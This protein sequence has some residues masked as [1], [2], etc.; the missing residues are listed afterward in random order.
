[1]TEPWLSGDLV[2]LAAPVTKWAKEIRRGE[3]VG[4]A[5]RRA[6]AVART[7]PSGPVFL[8]LPMD[9]LDQEVSGKT[10]PA[11]APPRLGPSPD[12]ERLAERLA[13]LDPDK[14]MVV[15]GDDL[16]ASV[17]GGLTAFVEAGAFPVWGTQLTSRVAFPS[18]HPCW[19]GVLKPDFAIMREHFEKAK[20][21]VLVGGRAFVA[22]PYRAAE[23]VPEGVAVLHVADN[24]EAFGREHAADMALIGDIGATLAVAAN[25]LAE[26]VDRRAVEARLAARGAHKRAAMEALRAEILAE[27]GAP[28]SPDAAVLAALDALPKDALIANDSAATFGRVQELMTTRPGPLLLLARRRARLQHAGR[29]RRV[30]RGRG[31]RRLVRRGRRGDVLAAGLVE[32]RAYPGEGDLL[33]VQQPP[34]RRPAERR[35]KPRLCQRRRRPLRRHG[36]R[37]PCDRFSGARRI[38]GRARRAR[39]RPGGDRRGGRNRADAGRAEP[40]GD[41]HPVAAV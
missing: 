17:S 10:P 16:P 28:L 33:R 6:F 3:D 9:I 29:R 21:I 31:A 37:G 41:R 25:R 18:A 27:A 1:M 15:L 36:D 40:G 39:R 23:P 14:V 24:P 35:E 34:L 11:S 2:A 12:A 20:A 19:A 4:Q 7:A 26:T 32:R 5:L 8:S 22:Y 13:D 30:A 38:D